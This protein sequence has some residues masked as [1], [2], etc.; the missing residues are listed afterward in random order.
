MTDEKKKRPKP[1]SYRPPKGR[2]AEFDALVAASGLSANAY[3]NSRIFGTHR[4]HTEKQ[5]AARKLRPAAAL[6]D[7]LHEIALLADDRIA[8]IVEAAFDDLDQLR[9]ELFEDMRR[10]P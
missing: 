7:K 6:A 5:E 2:E 9:G 10:K 8:L 4:R 3:I 1:K